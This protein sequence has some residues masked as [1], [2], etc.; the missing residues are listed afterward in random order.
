MMNKYA[1]AL[2]QLSPK[3]AKQLRRELIA[4]AAKGGSLHDYP[5]Y[6]IL[7]HAPVGG[8]TVL[9]HKTFNRLRSLGAKLH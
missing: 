3:S 7:K 1:E 5:W 9:A 4:Q 6:D 8:A 2:D